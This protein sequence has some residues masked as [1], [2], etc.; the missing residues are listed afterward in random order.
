MNHWVSGKKDR[1]GGEG[2]GGEG[3][4]GGGGGWGGERHLVWMI[5]HT[6]QCIVCWTRHSLCLSGIVIGLQSAKHV[7]ICVHCTCM[8]LCAT[9]WMLAC[10]YNSDLIVRE[11]V[12]CVWRA[13]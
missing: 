4:G 6:V 9:L 1:Y 3:G 2:R 10:L 11:M 8:C 7:H 5:V 12:S 13:W